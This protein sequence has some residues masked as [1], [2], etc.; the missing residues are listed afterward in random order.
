[1]IKGYKWNEELLRSAFVMALVNSGR[2]NLRTVQRI[3]K[4]LE[5]TW[6]AETAIKR[7]HKENEGARDTDFVNKARVEDDPIRSMRAMS[8][9]LACNEKTIRDCVSED[10]RRRSYK[11]QDKRR[12]KS[13]KVI[14]NLKHSKEPRML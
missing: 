14:N 1:E 7:T 3:T 4:K 11:M 6:D 12:V 2:V 5:D 10:L 9:D 8:R 13:T